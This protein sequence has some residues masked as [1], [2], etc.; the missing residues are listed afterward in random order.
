MTEYVIDLQPK[1]IEM[2]NQKLIEILKLPKELLSQYTSNPYITADEQKLLKKAADAYQSENYSDAAA[3]Y[4]QSNVLIG[5]KNGVNINNNNE[6]S[7]WSVLVQYLLSKCLLKS[8]KFMDLLGAQKILLQL[9]KS[10]GQKYPMI[11]YAL[12]EIYLKLFCFE[13]A[14]R[15]INKGL[16]ILNGGN[17]D[18]INYYIPLTNDIIV[19]ST[20]Q[21]LSKRMLNL[22]KQC[23][24]WHRPD[25]LCFMTNCRSNSEHH[26]SGR[27]IY[28]NSP[29]YNGMVI[30]VCDNINSCNIIFHSACWKVQKK[31][32]SPGKKM[33]DRDFLL[34]K[35]FTPNCE[36]DSTPSKIERIEIHNKNEV[37]HIEIPPEKRDRIRHT[38]SKGAIHKQKIKSDSKHSKQKISLVKK[39][40]CN[41]SNDDEK[42][43]NGIDAMKSQL[44]NLIQLRN[45][46]FNID[47][48]NDWRP[49]LQYYGNIEFEAKYDKIPP[50]PDCSDVTREVAS[51]KSFLYSYFYQ[52]I[53]KNGPVKIDSLQETWDKATDLVGNYETLLYDSNCANIAEFLIQSSKFTIISDYLC[54]PESIPETYALVRNNACTSFR[55]LM[56]SNEDDPQIVDEDEK[57]AKFMLAD[58]EENL[59]NTY[60]SSLI[61]I[62]DNNLP[63]STSVHENNILSKNN[64]EELSCPSQIITDK[65]EIKETPKIMTNGDITYKNIDLS[66]SNS[67][68]SIDIKKMSEA[69]A[70][71]KAEKSIQLINSLQ[72]QLEATNDELKAKNIQLIDMKMSMLRFSLDSQFM[73]ANISI[74]NRLSHF[75]SQYVVIGKIQNILMNMLGTQLPLNHYDWAGPIEELQKISNIVLQ[76]YNEKLVEI[77]SKEHCKDIDDVRLNV[78]N[79]PS[80]PNHNI[81]ELLQAAFQMYYSHF[82]RLFATLK[83]I[84]NPFPPQFIHNPLN[85]MPPFQHYPQYH[86]FFPQQQSTQLPIPPLISQF[87]LIRTNLPTQEAKMPNAHNEQEPKKSESNNIPTEKMQ[88]TQSNDVEIDEKQIDD[89]T[90]ISEDKNQ[91]NGITDKDQFDKSKVPSMDLLLNLL[92][93]RNK[94]VLEYDLLW[95]VNQVR[96]MFNDSLTGVPLSEIIIQTE[97]LLVHREKLQLAN[98]SE[99]SNNESNNVSRNLSNYQPQRKTSVSSTSSCLSNNSITKGLT[100][101]KNPWNT[102]NNICSTWNASDIQEECV[103]CF[104]MLRSDT[105]TLNS[106][107]TLRCQH[108]FHKKCINNWFKENRSCPTCRKYSTMDD[109]FPPL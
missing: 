36:R 21:E 15:E 27:N 86:N 58:A 62:N 109:E 39:L 3:F 37:K 67:K 102:I 4:K 69:I 2:L 104:E 28:F 33:S 80:L 43:F 46:N 13:D 71:D 24:G 73:I 89:V 10:E 70:K 74:Q 18:L 32:L 72:K 54:T 93:C 94:G 44:L 25:A 50:E 9:E 77:N 90:T 92:R 108:T 76:T 106:T 7:Q 26:L 99:N 82:Q 95:C 8:E 84:P 56:D 64:N 14:E 1:L 66:L 20:N 31:E 34:W 16:A 41:E 105:K 83:P 60:S 59:L 5:E 49:D 96:K 75:Q 52:F 23:T 51:L 81:S 97:Q 79:L 35:C 100:S 57:L 78:P 42:S 11:Y 48:N 6:K 45:N 12:A 19:E 55:Y 40:I 87:P 29:A 30:V 47:K 22:K 101:K 61:D 85:F 53:L 98:Y 88:E 68:N 91:P 65:K 103:I 63:A 38:P 17:G 107:Y